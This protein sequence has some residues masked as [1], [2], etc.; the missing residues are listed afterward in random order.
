VRRRLSIDRLDKVTKGN[1]QFD[2]NGDKV[3]DKDE[4]LVYQEWLNIKTPQGM[5]VNEFHIYLTKN[6]DTICNN[7]VSIIPGSMT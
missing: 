4:F 7:I 1:R 6:N 2:K 5:P 3:F